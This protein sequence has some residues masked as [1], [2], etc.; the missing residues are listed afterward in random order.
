MSCYL[1]FTPTADPNYY[2]VSYNSEDADR[3]G[4][5]AQRL[6]RSDVPLWYDYGL[7]Y[8]EKWE[9]QISGRLKDAQA[10][11]TAVLADVRD[12]DVILLHDMSDSSV[13]AALGIVD[14][15]LEQGFRFV[16]VSELAEIRGITL[17][18]GNTYRCFYK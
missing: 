2:F 11:Q 17:Q 3:V 16:T 4:L 12:G 15:L 9:G 6:C 10:V 8:G 13:D 5:I 1:G 14:S 18:P 7:E